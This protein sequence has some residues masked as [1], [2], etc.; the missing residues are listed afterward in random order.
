MEGVGNGDAAPT[1]TTPT[2]FPLLPASPRLPQVLDSS[3]SRES[4]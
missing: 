1:L 4:A 2:S 3:Q